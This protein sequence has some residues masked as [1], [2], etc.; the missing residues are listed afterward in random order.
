M[1]GS[2]YNFAV[3]SNQT[4]SASV[5]TALF[6]RFWN[7]KGAKSF[8][9]RMKGLVCIKEESLILLHCFGNSNFARRSASNLKK[10]AEGVTSV[11]AIVT[12]VKCN[13][14]LGK[15]LSSIYHHHLF[16]YNVLLALYKRHSR[17]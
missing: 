9:E 11:L 10:K 3:V 12:V 14:Q 8:K 7:L 5:E 16:C 15:A 4:L 6:M 13:E 2:P 1:Y 17:F